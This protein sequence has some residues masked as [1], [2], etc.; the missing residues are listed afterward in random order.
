MGLGQLPPC[1]PEGPES[2]T[3]VKQVNVIINGTQHVA[4]ISCQPDNF[5]QASSINNPEYENLFDIIANP[6]RDL[7]SESPASDPK[8]VINVGG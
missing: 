2:V 1:P 8:S 6:V 4:G 5:T 3:Y 7:F